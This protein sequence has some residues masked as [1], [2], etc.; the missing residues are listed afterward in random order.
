MFTLPVRLVGSLSSLTAV[1]LVT[2]VLTVPRPLSAE[3][4]VVGLSTCYYR[5][6]VVDGF[7]ARWAAGLDCEFGFMSCLREAAIGY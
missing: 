3:P 4:C 7:W 2:F 5:A 6:A 1:A